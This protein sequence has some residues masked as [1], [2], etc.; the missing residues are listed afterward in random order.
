MPN[1]AT[2]PVHLSVATPTPGPI[3]VTVHDVTGRVLARL[4]DRNTGGRGSFLWNGRDR[5]GQR[6]AAGV[7]YLHIRAGKRSISKKLTLL[8]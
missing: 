2:A 8:D 5:H 6:V 1:P 4:T 7:Y 3:Q